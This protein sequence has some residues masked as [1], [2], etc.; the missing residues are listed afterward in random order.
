[1]TSYLL[2]NT[3]SCCVVV[4]AF[5]SGFSSRM[6]SQG[7][8]SQKWKRKRMFE[9]RAERMRA[10]KKACLQ[11]TREESSLER[12]QG[13][14]GDGGGRDNQAGPSTSGPGDAPQSDD[15]GPHQSESENDR[16]S[17]ESSSESDFGDDDAQGI[18]DD[19]VVSLP[20]LQ[21]K[22]L[23]VLL[24]QSFRTRQQMNV[25]DAAQESASITEKTVRLYRKEFFEEKGKFK[26]SRQGKYKRHCL[27][28]EENLRLDAAMWI[29]ENAYKKGEANMQPS[30]SASGSMTSCFPHMIFLQISPERYL[31]E[32]QPNGSISLDIGHSHTRRV[33]MWMAMRGRTS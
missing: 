23:S 13:T 2:L 17:S 26:E 32:L 10:A 19:W 31:F 3:S 18:F 25:M 7:E 1:M 22:T 16:G 4:R 14:G 30:H 24:M 29:R 8:E 6:A 27:L 20:A 33:C 15:D 11:E 21:R 5:L 12:D 9:A 28:N